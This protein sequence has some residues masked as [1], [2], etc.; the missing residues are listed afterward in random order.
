[1]HTENLVINDSSY[2][3]AVEAISKELPKPNTETALALVVEAVNPINGSTFMVSSKEEE[4]V[5]VFDLVGEEEADGLNTLF[6]SVDIVAKEEVVGVWREA[7]I[8][9]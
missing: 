5:R 6:P 7:T 9:K 1:M 2:W 4:V 8:L 3:K